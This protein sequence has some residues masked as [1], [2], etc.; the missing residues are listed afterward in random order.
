MSNAVVPIHLSCPRVLLLIDAT[1]CIDVAGHEAP[2]DPFAELPRVGNV[3]VGK[4]RLPHGVTDRVV[5]VTDRGYVGVD[6]QLV[7]DELVSYRWPDATDLAEWVEYK[8]EPSPIASEF[9]A[10]FADENE[11]RA[12]YCSDDWLGGANHPWCWTD[13]PAAKCGGASS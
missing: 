4:F 9:G 3:V 13:E 1:P 12:Y 6:G 5:E 2:V 10:A 11:G 7:T 8:R